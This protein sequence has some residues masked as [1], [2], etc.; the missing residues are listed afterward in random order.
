MES[1]NT[2]NVV[3]CDSTFGVGDHSS[4]S[5]HA[6]EPPPQTVYAKQIL[7]LLEALFLELFSQSSDFTIF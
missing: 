6:Q 1:L 4:K 7:N 5:Q 3:V 2:A